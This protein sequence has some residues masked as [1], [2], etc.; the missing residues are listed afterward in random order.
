MKGN[1]CRS[2]F[3]ILSKTSAKASA[4]LWGV[5]NEVVVFVAFTS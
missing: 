4:V 2:F 5:T 3:I 1:G